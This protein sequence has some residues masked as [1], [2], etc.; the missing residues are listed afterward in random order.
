MT[1]KSEP[2]DEPRPMTNEFPDEWT[3]KQIENWTNH[4]ESVYSEL[5]TELGRYW[6]R[7]CYRPKKRNEGM[8]ETDAVRFGS[9]EDF[10]VAHVDDNLQPMG[11][12]TAVMMREFTKQSADTDELKKAAGDITRAKIRNMSVGQQ[13]R[14]VKEMQ[15]VTEL[16]GLAGD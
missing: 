13:D 10:V 5:D 4:G 6:Y 12:L 15:R 1:D 3:P 7:R 8:M 11:N 16:Y 2:Y 9:P 14:L